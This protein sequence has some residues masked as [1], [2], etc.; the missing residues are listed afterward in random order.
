MNP[1][2]TSLLAASIAF[3]GTH[4]VLS[5]PLRAPLVKLT[6]ENGF[7]ILYSLVA[8]ATLGWMV[9]AF[10]GAP[11]ADLGSSG[12]IG[13]IIAS[14]LTIPAV[15]LLL[16]SFRG[17]PALPMPGAKKAAA[18]EPH[19]VFRVTRHPMMWSM[20]L[21]AISHLVLWWSTRTLVVA[22]AVLILALVGA[23][24]QD[25]KKEALM[26]EAWSGWETKTSYWPK[27][28]ALPGAG[29]ILWLVALVVWGAL[30]FAHIHAAGIPAGI[31]RW[32]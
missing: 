30:T 32:L 29:A 23:R 18:L 19:G 17:N 15:V 6:G 7:A 11:Q 14:L 27:W 8:F 1:A 2:L 20:A 28:G 22:S 4:F 31:W 5:H 9:F 3:V 25:R 16:G 12:E 26:G 21:W 10:R 24:L 13:W